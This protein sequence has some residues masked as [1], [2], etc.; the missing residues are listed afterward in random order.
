MS[1]VEQQKWKKVEYSRSKIIKSGKIIKDDNATSEQKEEAT[2]VID[3]W[4]A[5]HAFPLHIIYMHLRRMAANNKEIIVAERLKRLDSIIK[6]LER[7]PSMSL[8]MMQ[9]LGGC[10]FI[11]PSIDDVY[12]YANKYEKS[13]KRHIFKEK[14]DYIQNPKKSGYRSLHMVYEYHSDTV[15][16]YNKNMLIEIQYRTHLQ[17]LWATAVETVGL[18]TKQ[19]IKSGQGNDD[20]K[21]FFVLISSL[22]AMREDCPIVPGTVNDKTAIVSEIREIDNKCHLIDM[23]SAIR[24]AVNIQEQAFSNRQGYYI[25][26]L[27]YNTKRLRIKYYKPSQIEEA[28]KEYNEIEKSKNQSNIDAV[29]VRVE[30]FQTLKKAYPNYFTDIDEFLTLVSAYLRK[31]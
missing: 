8:W 5:A 23:L 28:N 9:D 26:I 11:V 15:D 7:E 29:L 16:T 25:L 13:R 19:A 18:F 10:R 3:N 30:S 31:Y 24:V 21:R 27:N 12:K 17:H 22:F 4:R 1:I 14:Y 2:L 20:V 6:K